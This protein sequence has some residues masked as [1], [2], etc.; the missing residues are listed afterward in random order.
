MNDVNVDEFTKE[1]ERLSDTI[2]MHNANKGVDNSEYFI[3]WKLLEIKAEI[4]KVV[5]L[6]KCG[7]LDIASIFSECDED[8]LKDFPKMLHDDCW[9]EMT[10]GVQGICKSIIEEVMDGKMFEVKL[11]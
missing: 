2:T 1:M 5:Y 6:V 4:A 11:R 9:K 7:D 8:I 10:V 3:K